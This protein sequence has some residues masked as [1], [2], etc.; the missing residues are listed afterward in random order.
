[1]STTHSTLACWQWR[2]WVSC[3]LRSGRWHG[4]EQAALLCQFGCATVGDVMHF[5]HGHAKL[6]SALVL[7]LE[8]SATV[9]AAKSNELLFWRKSAAG[10]RGHVAYER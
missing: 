1:M 9:A 3:Q 10:E 8:F 2:G 4:I 7:A 6:I 5:L